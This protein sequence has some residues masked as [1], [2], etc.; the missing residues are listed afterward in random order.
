MA[1]K[2]PRCCGHEHYGEGERWLSL[3]ELITVI[4][5]VNA[6]YEAGDIRAVLEGRRDGEHQDQEPAPP[7][8]A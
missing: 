6:R 7:P 8:P 4:R 1:R 5:M 3:D 2:N